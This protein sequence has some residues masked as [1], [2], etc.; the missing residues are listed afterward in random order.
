LTDADIINAI[1]EREGGFVDDPEDRGGATKY[2]ITQDTLSRWLGRAATR[3][4]VKSLTKTNAYDIYLHFYLLEPN[5]HEIRNMHL[6]ELLVD[7]GVNHGTSR[8]ARWF[9]EAVGVERDGVIG[10]KTMG[11][12]ILLNENLVFYRVCAIRIKF[13]AG[14]VAHTPVQ[15]KFLRGWINRATEFLTR[16]FDLD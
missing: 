9:Q 14:I 15:V 7:C 13:Y 10:P 2:G 11:A 12:Y 8:A 5:F 4:E 1:I 6:R 3:D 16:P